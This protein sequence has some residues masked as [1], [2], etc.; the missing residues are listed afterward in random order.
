MTGTGFSEHF[1]PGDALAPQP[2]MQL[3][4]VAS[5]TAPGVSKSYATSGG[6]NKNEAVQSVKVSWTNNTPTVQNVYAMVTRGGSS[7]FLQARSRGYLAERHGYT[8]DP[9]SAN[10]PT[11]EVSRHGTGMDNGKGGILATGTAY[12]V[13]EYRVNSTTYPLLPHLTGLF[14]VLPGETFNA[15]VDVKFISEFWENTQIDGGDAGTAS[16]FVSGEVQID[17]F[18]MPAVPTPPPRPIP[19]LLNGGVPMWDDA[20]STAN[21]VVPMVPGVQAGDV[22]VAVVVNNFGLSTDINPV[23][24]GWTLLTSVN[25]GLGGWEDTHLKIYTRVATASEPATY[26]FTNGLLAQEIA[27]MFGLRHASG[28]IE[29]G[30]YVASA[31]RRNFL[32]R[33]KGHIA[34][35]I[36]RKGK[37]L[38]AISYFARN[39]FEGNITQ[40]VPDG[41]TE[42]LGLALS[43]SSLSIAY[44][45]DPPR[46]TG[47]RMFIPSQEP[48]WPGRSIAVSLVIPGEMGT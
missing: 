26:S 13:I 7:V 6:G 28:D 35:S 30:W 47:D 41:M 8:I 27:V 37:F 23:E 32:E 10:I 4:Q 29:D 45:A 15:Q 39:P 12:G 44:M 20:G 22:L 17:V 31:L 9:S 16:G 42:M 36:D 18:A 46:P 1:A 2:W 5:I 14:G 34:P 25:D 11:T 19:T 43:N 21:A 3:R 24:S 48:D 38:V 33:D 40:T